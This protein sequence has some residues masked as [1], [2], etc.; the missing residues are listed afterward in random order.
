VPVFKS[1]PSARFGLAVRRGARALVLHQFG[2]CHIAE[3]FHISD[4]ND[5][6]HGGFNHGFRITAW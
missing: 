3:I 1:I 5:T 2:D 6:I 4:F